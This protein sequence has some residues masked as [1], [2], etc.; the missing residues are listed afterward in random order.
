MLVNVVRPIFRHANIHGFIERATQT[1]TSYT[2]DELSCPF[3]KTKGWRAAD[4]I[5]VAEH[6]SDRQTIQG[7][8]DDFHG[9]SDWTLLLALGSMQY[10]LRG[11]LQM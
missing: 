7:I 3:N 6:G 10:V 8:V 2:I 1:L 5:I 11:W 4:P 9:A